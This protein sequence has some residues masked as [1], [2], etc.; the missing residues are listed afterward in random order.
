MWIAVVGELQKGREHV[1]E[2]APEDLVASCGGLD[3]EGQYKG[4]G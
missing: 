1:P 2:T 4:V 3:G